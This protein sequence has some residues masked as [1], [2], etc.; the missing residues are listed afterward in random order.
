MNPATTAI[1][2]RN[3]AYV[4]VLLVQAAYQMIVCHHFTGTYNLILQFFNRTVLIYATETWHFK[5][6]HPD[7]LRFDNNFSFFARSTG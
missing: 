4:A 5:Q 3:T 7:Y 6:I 1:E 2:A